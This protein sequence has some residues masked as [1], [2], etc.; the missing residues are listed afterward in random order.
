GGFGSGATTC[1]TVKDAC[2]TLPNEAGLAS[3]RPPPPPPAAF[4]GFGL[5]PP[6]LPLFSPA[7]PGSGV[8]CLSAHDSSPAL[9]AEPGRKQRD[10][11]TTGD[12][13]ENDQ[14]NAG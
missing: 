11:H 4:S 3:S 2:G 7:V 1:G 5:L 8:G 9:A 12:N 13:R 10:Q 6:P 14:T